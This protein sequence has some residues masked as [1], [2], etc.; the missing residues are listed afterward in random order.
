MFKI[1]IIGLGGVG[2][3]IGARLI[4]KNL[5]NISLFARG[6]HYKAIKKSG[7][8]IKDMNEEFTVTPENLINSQNDE[9]HEIFDIIFITTK[10]YS[11]KEISKTLN[12]HTNE[13]TLIIPL[14]NGINHKV[15]LR[16][17]I[18]KGILLEGCIYIL[19]NIKEA[20]YIQKK[21][22]TFYLIFGDNQN[23]FQGKLQKLADIL[24]QS[25]LKSKLSQNIEYDCWTK[26]LLI[27][28]F[29]TL[30]SYFEK[31]M[32]Y[33]LEKKMSLLKE[34]LDEII[35]VANALGVNI[36]EN[37]RAKVIN[38]VQNVSYNSK[39]SMQLDFEN[40][41]KTELEALTGY[42]VHEARNLGIEVR[43]INIMYEKLAKRS[44]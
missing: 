4:Q 9:S 10:S 33:I 18:Q 40:S 35:T 36:G 13:D 20:G 19:S 31:P 27:S 25:G 28:S 12:Q 1:G 43:N 5:A 15:E 32:G 44:I 21:A 29:A 34:V 24:N 6:E 23:R 41:K 38:Q 39:T 26:Y 22:L 16:N 8:K 42:I 2:G 11:F 7:L 37:E 30:T 17:Y 3:Y 14:S